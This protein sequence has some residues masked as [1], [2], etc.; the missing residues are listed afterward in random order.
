MPLSPK[1]LY[2][3]LPSVSRPQECVWGVAYEIAAEDVEAVTIHLDYREK[4]G[5][6]MVKVPFHPGDAGCQPFDLNIYIGTETNPFF[7]G[8]C[9]LDDMAE[10]ISHSVGPSGPNAEY[11]FKLAEAMRHLMPHVRDSHLFDLEQ[12]VKALRQEGNSHSS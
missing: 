8:P 3:T 2:R 12:R 1:C 11:L 4:G 9:N 6:E 10:Q 5:Y 7:L